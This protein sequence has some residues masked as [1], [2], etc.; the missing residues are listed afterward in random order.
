MSLFYVGYVDKIFRKLESRKEVLKE[1]VSNMYDCFGEIQG[2]LESI[3]FLEH[4]QNNIE[5]K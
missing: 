1:L 2:V 4:L 3:E 5:D